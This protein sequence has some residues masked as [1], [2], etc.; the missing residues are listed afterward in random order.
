M[1]TE[2]FVA[3]MMSDTKVMTGKVR[4]SYEHLME[5]AAAKGSE[6]K[7]YSASI[8]IPKSDTKCIEVIEK[9]VEN[10][11]QDGIEKYGKSFKNPKMHLPIHD[12]DEKE[13]PAYADSWYINISNKQKPGIVGPDRKPITDE[14]EVYSGMWARFTI[15]FYPYSVSGTGVSASLQNCQKLEDDEPLGGFKASAAS[16]FGAPDEDDDFFA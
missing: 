4:V 5:P 6:V 10:A 11:V 13:D 2:N 14:T 7:K 9:A 12:G 8:I 16:D 3:K 15:N 1:S